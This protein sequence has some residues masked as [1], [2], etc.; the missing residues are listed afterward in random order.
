MENPEANT[1]SPEARRFVKHAA[2][3]LGILIILLSLLGEFLLSSS[4][5]L[6]LGQQ[7]IILVG[8]TMLIS[9]FAWNALVKAYRI[10]A[11]ILLNTLLLILLLEVT[12]MFILNFQVANDEITL[13]SDQRPQY[14]ATSNQLRQNLPYYREQSWGSIYWENMSTRTFMYYPFVV[15]RTQPMST[16][17]INIDAEGIRETAG[18]VCNDD[19]YMIFVMGGS[20]VWG[21]GSPDMMTIPSYLQIAISEQ[22]DADICVMNLGES[23]YVSNQSLILLEMYLRRGIIPD[24][25]IFYDGVNDVGGAYHEDAVGMHLNFMDMRDRYEQNSNMEPE[26]WYVSTN[27]Y[28]LLTQHNQATEAGLVVERRKVSVPYTTDTNTGNLVQDVVNNYLGVYQSAQALGTHYDF[29][30]HFFWQP[31]L[32]T[33]NKTRTA[34]EN[35]MVSQIDDGEF[36]DFAIEVTQNIRTT[37]QIEEQLTDISDILDDETDEIFID[38]VHI[39]PVGNAIVADAI[40]QVVRPTVSDDLGLIEIDG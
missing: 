8:I 5:G 37:A 14:Y 7:I 18:P 26:P 3:G 34:N 9:A 36:P 20:T 32:V 23:A 6:G 10:L 33:S 11:G 28:R 15:W 2:I 4:P 31:M 25:V 30:I 21:T 27:T 13:E 35:I 17:F 29:E 24:L 16:E 19:S 40:W 22:V 1:L 39:T 38:H 12:A